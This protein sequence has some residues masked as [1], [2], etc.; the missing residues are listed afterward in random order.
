MDDPHPPFLLIRRLRVAAGAEVE[1]PFRTNDLDRNRHSSE[2]L[3]LTDGALLVHLNSKNDNFP[4]TAH[5]TERIL[6]RLRRAI[7]GLSDR[8][9]VLPRDPQQ[10]R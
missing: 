7:E 5:P 2:W 4:P 9:P 3:F 1:P 8:L 6:P 10:S